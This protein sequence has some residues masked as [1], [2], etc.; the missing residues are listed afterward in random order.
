MT[1]TTSPMPDPFFSLSKSQLE[2]L[3]KIK[4]L[5]LDVDGIL[6]DSRIWWVEG[7]GW[8]RAFSVRDGYG[9]KLLMK[10]GCELGFISGGDSKSVRERAHFLGVKHVYLG[11]ENKIVA[12]DKIM[13]DTGFKYEQ[14]AFMGD[15]LYDIPVLELVGFS[16]TVP[17][18]VP[19]VQEMVHYITKGP[20]GNGAVRE[21]CDLIRKAAFTPKAH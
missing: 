18:A 13:H 6:T 9:M 10:Q 21:V 16:A 7:T 2:R 4:L 15:D 8:T 12:L 3:Q 11:D 19:E 20:A 1:K 17:D 14:I 5:I